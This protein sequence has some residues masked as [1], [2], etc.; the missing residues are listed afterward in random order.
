MKK[1]IMICGLFLVMA[2]PSHAKKALDASAGK[3]A[4]E[5]CR[6]CHSTP[7][8]SNVAPVFHVPK[9]GGQRKSYIASALISYKHETRAR[10]SMLANSENLTEEMAAAIAEY[11]ETAGGKKSK[12]AYTGGD[13]KNGKKLAAS[14]LGCHTKDLDDGKT[15]PILAGQHGNY[16]VK[17]MQDYQKGIRKDAA[18][19][20]MVSSFSEDD[21]KDIAAYFADMKGLS[22]IK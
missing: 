7:N 22:I 10:T 20:G 16:L 18:M 12:A 2:A 13:A 4:F 1:V 3:D 17:V 21:L 15:A 14:C 11:T 6:G 19:Q 5:T 9:I 8:Y